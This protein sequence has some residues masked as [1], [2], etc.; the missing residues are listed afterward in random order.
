M[1][2]YHAR[3][4]VHPIGW[5]LDFCLEESVALSDSQVSDPVSIAT[6]SIVIHEQNVT[7]SPTV[8]PWRLPESGSDAVT[9]NVDDLVFQFG[10]VFYLVNGNLDT[11]RNIS[12][13]S[14]LFHLCLQLAF[15]ETPHPF[16]ILRPAGRYLMKMCAHNLNHK[17][18]HT[19]G[20]RGYGK[21]IHS[22]FAVIFGFEQV[23]D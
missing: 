11:G 3:I 6:G 2:D 13:S 5:N 14:G 18:F 10:L 12:F 8:M 19:T 15:D 21:Q 17:Q 4:I 16:T 20:V 22:E 23:F 9:V 1:G 7:R